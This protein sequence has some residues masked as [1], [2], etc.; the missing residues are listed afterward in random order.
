M[1]AAAS[2]LVA[3]GG[4]SSSNKSVD[5]RTETLETLS[6]NNPNKNTVITADI[7]DS[8]AKT[9]VNFLRSYATYE[10]Y[11]KLTLYWNFTKIDNCETGYSEYKEESDNEQNF[12]AK[13]TFDQCAYD[14]E[15]Q[16]EINLADLDFGSVVYD[17]HYSYNEYY[18]GGS[19]E[20]IYSDQYIEFTLGGF[21]LKSR[22]QDSWYNPDEADDYENFKVVIGHD[23]VV[24]GTYLYVTDEYNYL[25]LKDITGKKH[26]R[27]YA[28]DN[29]YADLNT[30]NS[31]SFDMAITTESIGTYR[32]ESGDGLEKC[33]GNHFQSGT[34]KVYSDSAQFMITFT[35][36]GEYTVGNVVM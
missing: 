14:Y 17:G 22:M 20:P 4:G 34:I 23:T 25:I 16:D 32:L 28:K 8:L 36:C 29:Y 12:L 33:D 13:M 30:L 27:N 5:L 19:Y 24:Q 10:L 18:N 2:G 26:L 9:A 3:C 1:V 11:N 6:F 35:G 7:K 15:Y 31:I 21:T